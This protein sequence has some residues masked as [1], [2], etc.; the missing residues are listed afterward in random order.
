M[1]GSSP[2]PGMSHEVY[3]HIRVLIGIVLG[4]S[5]TR[6]LSGVARLVQHPGK[7][8]IYPVHLIWVAIILI[9]SIHFWWWELALEGLPHW[10]FELFLF[11]LGYAFLF[12]LLANLLF[13]DQLD[14]YAGYQDYFLSR[15]GWFFGL[16]IA[17]MVADLADT[18][19]KGH[20]YMAGLSAEYPVRI[21]GTILL[22]LVAIA[23]RNARFHLAFA[24][25]Y[26][27]YYVS[28]IIRIYDPA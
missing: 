22:S 24:A 14:D 16:F 21:G 6:L 27:V 28:W 8:K 11:V 7:V 26:F 10:R 4:L 25:L 20:I 12:A 1:A 18:L 23:T 5:L 2:D 15:R 19:L 17:T 13:P 3:L 9:T